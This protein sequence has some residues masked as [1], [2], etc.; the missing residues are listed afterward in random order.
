MRKF[1]KS[2]IIAILVA[3]L[4]SCF[5]SPD[6]GSLSS[7]FVVATDRDV[8]VDFSAYSTYHISDTIPRI[9]DNPID[10]VL[11]GQEALDIVDRIKANMDARGYTFVERSENPDIALIPSVIR[12][13]NIGSVC[14]GWWGGYP[15]YWDPFYWGYPGTGYYYPYCGFYSYDDGSLNL[16]MFDLVNVPDN[17]NIN[18][19]WGSVMF[20]ALNPSDE[21]NLD[22]ALNAL[23][24]AF[25]QSP[26]LNN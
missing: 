18:A 12:I 25:E 8:Q 15:G 16:E 20:G 22:R 9:T 6:L 1:I 4:H 19:I 14:S 17:N 13:R 7:D 5:N 2:L 10:T 26:Y 23:D 24:Q 21:V 11:V 3:T